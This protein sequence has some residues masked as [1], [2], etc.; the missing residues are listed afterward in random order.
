MPNG[1]EVR[2]LHFKALALYGAP[3]DKNDRDTV[4]L[5]N[6]ECHLGLSLPRRAKAG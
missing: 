5:D 1:E 2:E 6:V 4:F 3:R